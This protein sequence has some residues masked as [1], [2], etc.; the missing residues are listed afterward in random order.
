MGILFVIIV[1]LIALIALGGWRWRDHQ[2]D[3][4]AWASLASHQPCNPAFFDPSLIEGLPGPAQRF[5]R[6][7]IQPGTPLY[8]VAELS[9]Q[10]EFALGNKTTPGYVAMHAEQILAAPYGFVW[11]LKT[12][13]GPIGIS[14]SD[15]AVNN[16]SW[17]RFWL[18]L[19][20]PVAR[21]GGNPDHARSAFGRY[22]AEAVFWS[23][24]ALLPSDHVQWEAID[25][26]KVRV[27]MEYSDKTQSVDLAVDPDGKVSEV[28]FQR[29]SNANARREF[30]L[31]PFGGYLSGYKEFGGY[32]LPTKIE[33][34]NFFATPD[35][36]PFFKANV[37]DIRFPA[38]STM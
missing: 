13:K 7:A 29:W 19:L 18:A 14:G 6:S 35:Y 27:T 3:H 26:S 12:A 31:Q 9:M 22:V 33:A 17:S 4:K 38:G 36:F 32:C 28:V 25:D 15:A 5:F 16:Q 1:I 21:A 24:A 10:G 20:L 2:A 11:R 34:G 37:M 23:P 8:T 30:Q